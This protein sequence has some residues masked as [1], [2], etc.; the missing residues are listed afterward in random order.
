MPRYSTSAILLRKIDFGDYDVIVTFFSMDGGKLSAI[1]KSAKKSTRRFLGVLEPF[2]ELNIVCEKSRR[3]RL[4]ILQE[5]VLTHPFSKIREDIKK[6]AYASYWGE[7]IYEWMEEGEQQRDV[8]ELYL[9][10]LGALDRGH[11][12]EAALSLLFQI[13]FLSLSGYAPNLMECIK[14]RKKL[15]E[16]R[17]S[18]V[19]FNLKEGGL[20]C[21]RCAVGNSDLMSLQKGTIKQLLWIEKGALKKIVRV[22][23][24]EQ[25]IKESLPLLEAFT[26]YHLGKK[27]RSLS[28]LQQIR[29]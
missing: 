2:S 18:S 7:L 28:F 25:A 20:V 26:P 27:P 5:A 12:S 9:Y 23:F 16:I 17:E 15:E 4:P 14:C 6:T 24:T 3:G 19:R 21:G 11:Q 22:R 8:Y 13:R 29:E 1:A 10:V